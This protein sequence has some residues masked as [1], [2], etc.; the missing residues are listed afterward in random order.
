MIESPASVASSTGLRVLGKPPHAV[1]GER[2]DGDVAEPR[3][4]EVLGKVTLG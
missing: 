4:G 1:V 3:G 2:V